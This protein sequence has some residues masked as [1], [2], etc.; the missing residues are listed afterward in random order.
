[1]VQY[2]SPVIVITGLIFKGEPY[3]SQTGFRY[4]ISAL[5]GN[6]TNSRVCPIRGTY[7]TNGTQASLS[8]ADTSAG[9][10]SKLTK[11]GFLCPTTTAWKM[12]HT[13]ATTSGGPDTIS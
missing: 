7:T 3:G 13:I 8:T 11:G 10:G 5:A 4:V 2:A 1:M 6:P 9:S 12:T